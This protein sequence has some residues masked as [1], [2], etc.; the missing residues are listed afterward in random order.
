MSRDCLRIR[1]ARSTTCHWSS[2]GEGQAEYGAGNDVPDDQGLAET[3]CHQGS[4]AATM[5]LVPI[6][7]S[8][9]MTNHSAAPEPRPAPQSAHHAGG[10]RHR[11]GDST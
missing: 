5:M 3:M 8:R 9:S 10:P 2:L 4:P 6:D 1:A 7:V 11:V